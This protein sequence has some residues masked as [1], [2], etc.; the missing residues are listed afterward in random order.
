M[1]DVRR[2]LAASD[3]QD[4]WSTR[5]VQ[6]NL[7]LLQQQVRIYCFISRAIVLACAMQIWPM[8]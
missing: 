4:I 2:Y 6:E 7:H 8:E 5:W 1:F 3:G